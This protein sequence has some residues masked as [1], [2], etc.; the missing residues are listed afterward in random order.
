MPTIQQVALLLLAGL[1]ILGLVGAHPHPTQSEVGCTCEP[2]ARP[3]ESYHIHV[4]FYPDEDIDFDGFSNNTHASRYARALRAKFI[5]HFNVPECPTTNMM[6][7]TKLCAF[8]VDE[9]GTGGLRNT[10][11]F[12]APN[13]AFF[14]PPDRY[15][16]TVPWMMA[17]RGDLDF[18]V[19]PNSC[20]FTCSPRDHLQWS[21]WGG[22]KWP[23]RFQMSDWNKWYHD[24]QHRTN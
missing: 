7:L 15:A 8:A 13:F 6:N 5:D 10:A 2:G 12:V 24:H 14:L 20:G 17:N 19:H 16:D 21:V 3:F 11:P 1:A 18:L 22:T 23:I 4:M 9:E